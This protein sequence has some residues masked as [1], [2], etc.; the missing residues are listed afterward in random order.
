MLLKCQLKLF[1]RLKLPI[2]FNFMV[3]GI[4]SQREVFFAIWQSQGK[5]NLFET[6]SMICYVCKSSIIGC[7]PALGRH[8]I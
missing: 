4:L 1:Q 3:F 2:L 7:L 5:Y 6:L 8:I